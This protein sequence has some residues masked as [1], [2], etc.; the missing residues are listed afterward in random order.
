MKQILLKKYQNTMFIFG[1]LSC[2]SINLR[3]LL[4]GWDALCL[5]AR[6]AGA[7]FFPHGFKNRG[8]EKTYYSNVTSIEILQIFSLSECITRKMNSFLRDF[9]RCKISYGTTNEY[10][11]NPIALNHMDQTTG[12]QKILNTP[13]NWKNPSNK[14]AREMGDR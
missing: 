12:I 6:K 10:W 2:E 11:K 9:S 7:F 5:A 8:I 4:H 1:S 14:R 13:K 3:A